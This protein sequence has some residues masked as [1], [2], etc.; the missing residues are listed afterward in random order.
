MQKKY[1]IW[2]SF[3]KGHLMIDKR[4]EKLADRLC[5]KYMEGL[6]SCERFTKLMNSEKYIYLIYKED[7]RN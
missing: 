4:V 3:D 2:K 6:I 7:G 1:E 5:R